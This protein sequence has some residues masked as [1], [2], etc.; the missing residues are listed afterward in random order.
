[1]RRYAIRQTAQP[2]EGVFEKAIPSCE[3]SEQKIEEAAPRAIASL[4]RLGG[5][6]LLGMLGLDKYSKEES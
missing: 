5:L 2:K 6:D 4:R 3:F 1:M